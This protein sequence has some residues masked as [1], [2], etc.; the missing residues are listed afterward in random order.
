MGAKPTTVD[1][2]SFFGFNTEQCW[3]VP[4]GTMQTYDEQ[5]KTYKGTCA[6]WGWT[7]KSDQTDDGKQLW[8]KG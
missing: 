7:K 1:S 4:I 8:R 2:H 3:N 6:S 5:V